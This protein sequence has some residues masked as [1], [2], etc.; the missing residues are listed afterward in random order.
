M[1]EKSDDAWSG[2]KGKERKTEA[3]VDGQCEC[4]LEGEGTVG[5][6]NTKLCCVEATCEIPRPHLE[7]GNDG[8][9]EEED[10]AAL[11]LIV[12]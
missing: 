3:E 12:G 6:G 11:G 4:G 8:V 2:G 7:V 10:T 5:G 1:W 9:E